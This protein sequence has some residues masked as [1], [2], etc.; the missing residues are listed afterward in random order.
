MTAFRTPTSTVRDLTAAI[1]GEVRLGRHDRMLYATDASLYQ[2][3][4]MAVV[5]PTSLDDAVRAARFCAD[6][7]LPMLPR[8]GG[9]SLAGQ[10]TN[11]AVVIDFS[12]HCRALLEVDPD[13]RRCRV[14][15]GITVDDLNDLLKPHRLF[16]APDPATSK[17]ANV[18]GCIGNNAAGSRSIIYGRT[19]ENLLGVDICTAEGARL[20]L[21]RGAAARDGRVG[22]L[23]TRVIEVVRRN[24]P[25]IRDRFPKT[26][27][28]NAGYALDMILAQLDADAGDLSNINLAH[29]LCGSEGTLGVT[30]GAELALHPL[31]VARGL[32]VV[33]FETLDAA[34]DAVVPILALKPSAVELLDDLVVSL[35]A[36]NNEYRRYVELLPTVDGKS[37]EAVLYVEFTAHRDPAELEHGFAALMNLVGPARTACHTDAAAMLAAWKLRKAGEPLLHGI[38]GRR[39]P[40]TFVEDNAVPPE[41][42]AEFVR[43]F[44]TIVERHG[45]R[46]AFW[47]HASVGV[48][49]VRP[50]LD[51]ADLDDRR[52][53]QEIAIEVADLAR[54]LGGVMS[55]EHGDGRIRGPLLE[56]Y[57]GPEL[58]RAFREIKSIFDPRNLLNPGNIVAPGPIDSIATH[59]RVRPEDQEVRVPDIDTYFRYDDHHGFDAA[60]ETCNGAGVC[61]KKSGGVMCPSYK[62]TLDERHSTRGRGNALRLAFTG[63]LNDG[64]PAWNDPETLETLDLCL[65]CKACKSECP[66][67]VDVARLKAE[68]LAQSDRAAG[69]P[70]FA[71]RF[72]SHVHTVNRLASLAPGLTN[73]INDSRLGKWALRRMLGIDPRRSMPHYATPLQR[74]WKRSK[75]AHENARPAVVL[76][77]DSFTTYNEPE[78]ALAA[79][80]VLEAFGYRVELFLGSDFGR[81]AISQGLLA[82]AIADAENQL[83]R[84]APFLDRTDQPPLLTVEPSTHSA[85][86]DDWPDLKLPQRARAARTLAART[87]DVCDFLE[88]HWDAHPKRPAIAC[89]DVNVS[90]H[91]HCHQQALAGPEPT[92]RL[93]QR[94]I[95]GKVV[96]MDTTC[97]GMAGAFGFAEHRFDLSR[98][99][100]EL[101]L[102]PAVVKAEPHSVVLATGASCRH[103]LR[104]LR[105]M[106][107]A[108]PLGFLVETLQLG[109]GDGLSVGH[110]SPV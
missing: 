28:R 74:Q 86:I 84:L 72:F 63:Q 89:R 101:S 7:G 95:A 60:V 54:S 30:L 12:P 67:N 33:G 98:R 69:G 52:R 20:R 51:I 104:D 11:E 109:S 6:R 81:A 100:A 77:A 64:R 108:H 39:K 99:I 38:P 15:P 36:A 87:L 26:I 25:L 103:Q 10:C 66:S 3:E 78:I 49:H 45:T 34:I 16:F 2:V 31:P 55:G 21:D 70:P 94:F 41:N 50:L 82:T 105:S 42:L 46:A 59:L 47:A 90:I 8:G 102:I 22:T 40:I 9:T 35:A 65:S 57:F 48:L 56:R 37:P 17:Q 58:M 19:A 1:E 110:D 43:R 85:I 107:A 76:L 27:R 14:E 92:R 4:P 61:R 106:R 97:C 79:R 68:Y 18:G 24:E 29:L 88:Q 91:A 71:R 73:A 5:I 80:Q 96:T 32:A 75:H 13:G 83:E 53:M 93:V 44:R 23:T 62:A